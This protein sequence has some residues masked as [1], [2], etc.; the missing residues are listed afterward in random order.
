MSY[1]A[2]SLTIKSGVERSRTILR[3]GRLRKHRT[4]SVL[5]S[6][7]QPRAAARILAFSAALSVCVQ[8]Q[9]AEPLIDTP[10]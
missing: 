2:K 5:G 7:G 8:G 6:T 4:N 10:L 3:A 9:S 1:V